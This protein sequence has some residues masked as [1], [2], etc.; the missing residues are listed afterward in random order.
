MFFIKHPLSDIHIKCKLLWYFYLGGLIIFSWLLLNLEYYCHAR[1]ALWESFLPCLKIDSLLWQTR[2]VCTGTITSNMIEV[3]RDNSIMNVA[4]KRQQTSH[5]CYKHLQ[6]MRFPF[7]S[8]Q[9]L[10]RTPS[11]SLSIHDYNIPFLK[12]LFFY[13]KYE[14]HGIT[15]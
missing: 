8:V 3:Y 5:H 6:D 10:S 14:G 11:H 12:G 1:S 7:R 4:K 15:S 9:T 13:D 2:A